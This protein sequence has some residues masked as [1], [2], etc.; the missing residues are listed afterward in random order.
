MIFSSFFL[1][2]TSCPMTNLPVL[3]SNE[4]LLS[5]VLSKIFTYMTEFKCL[6]ANAHQILLVRTQGVG[7][8]KEEFSFLMEKLTQSIN[9]NLVIEGMLY[10]E[11]LF[12]AG[13][14]FE[15]RLQPIIFIFLREIH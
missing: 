11:H 6:L 1:E 4:I 9:W 14:Y 8:I 15:N 13:A 10:R 3:L 7:E 2:N 12:I 5:Y